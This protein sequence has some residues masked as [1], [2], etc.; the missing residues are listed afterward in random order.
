MSDPA[1]EPT[2]ET[3]PAPRLVTTDP[4]APTAPA[5]PRPPA[6]R[7]RR[8]LIAA[9]PLALALGGGYAWVT[10]G[11][12]VETEDAYVQQDRVSVMPQVSGQIAEVNV[13]ENQRVKAGATLFTIDDASY[14][15]AVEQAQA[16]L[17]S[18]RLD[19]ERLKAAYDEAVAEADTARDSFETA[20]TQDDRQQKL[21]GS[22]VVSQSA[23]DDSALKLQIARGAVT[24]AESALV[25]ARASLAGDPAITTDRHPDVLEAL[26]ALHA[27]E[28]DLARTRVVAP[29]D[30]IVSQ[31]DRLQRG[32]YVT[33]AVPVLSLVAAG[34]SWIEANY[35]ETELTHMHPGQRAEVTVDTYADEPLTGEI[36]SIGAGT[37]S[38]FALLPPQNATGNWVKVVQRVPVRIGIDAGQ[39]LPTLR[40]GMSARVS[41]DTGH[42]RGLP[43]FVSAALAAVGLGAAT[44]DTAGTGASAATGDR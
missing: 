9:L 25:S 19:V 22:G 37:G 41:V 10:G 24:K 5:T 7:R 12:Y 44:A 39:D 42:A 18:A 30:G 27:A 1:P 2:T 11:R 16:R 15:N 23:A 6:R 43:G 3:K 26:A 38:E 32:Q 13:A 21:L 4:A 28:L 29:D 34:D 31:T 17:A 35:K 8:L 20:R 33:P 40:A 36:A 14:R